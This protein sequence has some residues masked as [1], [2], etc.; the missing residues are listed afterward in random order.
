M[1]GRDEW[2]SGFAARPLAAQG[3]LV[4]QTY[5]FKER[6]DIDSVSANRNLGNTE[7]QSLKHFA[8]LAYER[9]I[10]Y[11]DSRGMI[12][13]GH[14]GISGFSRT[15][16]FSAYA[17]THTKYDFGAGILTDG[18]DCGY[19]QYSAFPN[20]AWDANALAGG[21]APYGDGLKEWLEEA[22]GFNLDKVRTPMRLVAL[23]PES[24]LNSWE[25]YVGLTLQR[26]P[27]ELIEIPDASHLI[28]RPWD[29]QTAMQGVV[30]WFRFWLKGEEDSDPTK[31]EQYERWREL[32][33]LREHNERNV[34]P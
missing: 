8:A 5:Q 10:D 6:K 24:I 17:L 34:R 7:A 26:K 18:I 27:V 32:R 4:L 33:R 2:S 30:D 23:N 1:D 29:R 16:C 20:I 25:W 21:V 3:L 19:F 28:Q 12:D 13:P 9:A 11:L 14:V 15:V 22:P 31:A